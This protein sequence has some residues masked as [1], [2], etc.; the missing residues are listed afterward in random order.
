[1]ANYN[2]Y[3]FK[4]GDVLKAEGLHYLEAY[5]KKCLDIVDDGSLVNGNLNLITTPGTYTIEK[6]AVVVNAPPLTNNA[7]LFVI[8]GAYGNIIQFIIVDNTIYYRTFTTSWTSW[9]PLA[10]NLAQLGITVSPA[11]IN[12]LSVHS[13]SSLAENKLDKTEAAARVKNP[14]VI[15]SKEYDGSEKIEIEASDLGLGQ[16]IKFKGIQTSFPSDAANGDI[17]FLDSKEYIYYEGEWTELGDESNHVPNT[18]Q[19]KTESGLTGGGNLTKD[20]SIKHYSPNA[21]NAAAAYPSAAP[22]ENSFITQIKVDEF[23]HVVETVQDTITDITADNS[24]TLEN[25]A[26]LSM[27]N[28]KNSNPVNIQG[29][30]IIKV[31]ADKDQNKIVLSA[32]VD[33]ANGDDI[34]TYGEASVTKEENSLTGDVTFYFHQLKGKPGQSVTHSWEGTTLVL[35]SASGTTRT[36]LKGDSGQFESIA[37]AGRVFDLN[38][39]KTEGFY[40]CNDIASAASMTNCPIKTLFS[41]VVTKTDHNGCTQE[42]YCGLPSDPRRYFRHYK[43]GTWSEWYEEY[44]TYNKPTFD[45]IIS[46]ARSIGNEAEL[47]DAKKIGWYYYNGSTVDIGGAQIKNGFI[48]VI[49]A[50]YQQVFQRLTISTD[51]EMC[52]AARIF[53]GETWGPWEWINAPFTDEVVY[54]MVE[55][56]NGLTVYRKRDAEGK[57]WY[58][59]EGETEWTGGIPAVKALPGEGGGGGGDSSAIVVEDENDDGHLYIEMYSSDSY[60]DHLTDKNNPHKVTAEQIGAEV[61]GAASAALDAAKAYTDEKLGQTGPGAATP[62]W[63]A[64]EGA[65]GHILNRTHYVEEEVFL[66]ET[67]YISNNRIRTP[68][69][70]V[71]G[72]TYNVYW[73]GTKYECVCYEDSSM[74]TLAGK[75]PNG[76]ESYPFM[77]VYMSIGVAVNCESVPRGTI[78]ITTQGNVHKL[79]SKFLPESLENWANASPTDF[80]PAGY[81]LGTY[82]Q[83]LDNTHD[84]NNPLPTGLYRWG[85][86]LPANAPSPIGYAVMLHIARTDSDSIQKVWHLGIHS[87]VQISC[88]RYLSDGEG[89]WEW[90]NPPMTSD[91]EYRTTERIDGKAVFK[92]RDSNGKM[93]YCLEGGTAWFEGVPG[94]AP[95]WYGLGREQAAYIPEGADLNTRV[96]NG[97]YYWATGVSNVPFDRGTMLV[98]SRAGN[99]THQIAFRN[100]VYDMR[101]KV[102]IQTA[103]TWSEWIDWS[104]SA[105][106]PSGYGLGEN[107]KSIDLDTVTKSGNYKGSIDLGTNIGV[108]TCWCRADM[109]SDNYGTMTAHSE[110]YGGFSLKR[111]KN[112][113]M[114]SEW[115]WNNPPMAT[116]QEYRTTERVNGKAVYKKRDSEYRMWYRLDGDTVWTEGIPGAA[117]ARTLQWIDVTTA[118]WYKVGTIKPISP[119]FTTACRLSTGGNYNYA[120]QP[121][122][123][124]DA[125]SDYDTINAVVTVPAKK[126]AGITKVGFIRSEFKTFDVYV[127]YKHSNQNR[128]M[129]S[130]NML[131]GTFERTN[132]ELASVSESDMQVVVTTNQGS[133]DFSR[134]GLG[135]Y[136]VYSKPDEAL[137]NGYYHAW[138]EN[139]NN[140]TGYVNL[141]V[142]N[143]SDDIIT[144]TAYGAWGEVMRRVWYGGK[145]SEWGIENPPMAF[146][147]EY[148]TTERYDGKPVYC[149]LVDCGALPNATTKAVTYHGAATRIIRYSGEMRTTG[150]EFSLPYT[151]NGAN[152]CVQAISSNSINLYASYNASGFSAYVTV[153]YTKD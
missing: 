137:K 103:Y 144:Q 93:W 51:Y 4:D 20:L 115:E 24:T 91:V 98:V 122:A 53:N 148:R 39:C 28:S 132:F 37:I 107:V 5:L 74:P 21:E 70:L 56:S 22:A 128:I 131:R 9:N 101:I 40:F 71:I 138:L 47:N 111:T 8:N 34:D 15:G 18:R 64:P 104:P 6:N 78:A 54:R 152:V 136:T 99:Y 143:N 94:A 60:I 151:M 19:I 95:D 44:N 92:K 150:Q 76:D 11:I 83:L 43:D 57:Y 61:S 67:T 120:N 119:D 77:I 102:R 105:F 48:E 126:D 46:T 38:D 124:I 27:L 145:W 75:G 109:S 2:N 114:W 66:E 10:S 25:A 84:L 42:L 133:F 134:Y 30:G 110:I 58:R 100:D 153:W 73:N 23:G 68:N 72:E 135:S 88:E 69:P 86:S 139:V 45:N 125:V 96:K 108:A 146:G 32:T 149:K 90:T 36:N 116:N 106:A 118:G 142:M 1:M 33:A 29:N 12:E 59:L 35:N 49:T 97:W 52:A 112:N 129:F 113:G 16:A 140:Y 121:A 89:E 147:V 82:A 41:L 55:R 63:N 130:A 14:I 62:D 26:T 127:Y 65:A 117:P 31:A 85:A 87:G 50:P 123:I 80:A 79:D 3:G 7:K 81:G 141:L 13:P 17:I